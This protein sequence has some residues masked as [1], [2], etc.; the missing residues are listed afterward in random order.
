[1]LIEI[2]KANLENLTILAPLFDAY[3]IFY[4]Q[5]PDIKVVTDFLKERIMKKESIIFIAMID[6]M[7][8]GFTQLYP[9][10]SSVRLKPAWL[11]NDLYVIE[12][13][14]R[15]GVAAALLQ[16]TKQLASDTG[17]SWLLLQTAADNHT[18]QSLY[19]KNGWIKQSD[20]FYELPL[21]GFNQ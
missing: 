9:I 8:V 21:N 19:E 20:F 3:R 18:A 4:D 1:M 7:A 13:A 2:K 12:N 14:R 17:A 16:K 5:T 11:L 15:Q 6:S 10:F